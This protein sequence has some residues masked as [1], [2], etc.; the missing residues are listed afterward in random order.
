M[1]WSEDGGGALAQIKSLLV[2]NTLDSWLRTGTVPFSLY[3]AG[4]EVKKT[5]A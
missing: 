2:N 1:S 5:A 4:W 3:E